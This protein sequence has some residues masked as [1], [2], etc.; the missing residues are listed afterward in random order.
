V[1]FDVMVNDSK[2]I[3]NVVPENPLKA[4]TAYLLKTIRNLLLPRELLLPNMH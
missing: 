4:N 2:K 3:L 1:A